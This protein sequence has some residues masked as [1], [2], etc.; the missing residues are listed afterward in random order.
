MSIGAERTAVQN[1]F[2]RY[3]VEAGWTY[4]TPG[5][6]LDLRRGLSSPVLDN[7]LIGQLHKLNP[8]T[9]DHHWAEQVRDRSIRITPYGNDNC[10]A[11][12]ES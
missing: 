12:R 7:I 4:L 9:V 3:A 1:P 2:V 5:Q 8:D 10:V 11:C 6:A